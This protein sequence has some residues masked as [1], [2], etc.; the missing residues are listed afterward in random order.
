MAIGL[1]SV[2]QIG[3]WLQDW[4]YNTYHGCHDL[5][6]ITNWY[7]DI[8]TESV[9]SLSNHKSWQPWYNYY[10]TRVTCICMSASKRLIWFWPGELCYCH[11]IFSLWCWSQILSLTRSKLATFTLLWCWCNH[12]ESVYF[13]LALSPTT[14]PVLVMFCFFFVFFKL[15]RSA[16]WEEA[17]DF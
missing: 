1:C 13:C 17:V 6:S 9:G 8:F 2:W 16:K 15:N 7:V 14:V 4:I 3:W 11:W 12:S 5:S 10:I